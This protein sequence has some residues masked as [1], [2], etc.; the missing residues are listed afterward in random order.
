MPVC[1][2]CVCLKELALFGLRL[3]SFFVVACCLFACRF[4][5]YALCVFRPFC[6]V[7]LF[8]VCAVWARLVVC[9]F[10]YLICLDCGLPCVLFVF[11]LSDVLC[12]WVCFALNMFVVVCFVRF[13]FKQWLDLCYCVCVCV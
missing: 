1:V 9:D 2:Y 13:L 10:C 4:L 5:V 3:L 7:E 8:V 6:F 12:R 11:A